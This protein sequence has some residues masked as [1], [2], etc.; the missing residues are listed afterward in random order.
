MEAI[1][2]LAG[3][4]ADFNNLLAAIMGFTELAL[5]DLPGGARA[6]SP[7]TSSGPHR[8]AP[9][10]SSSSGSPPSAARHRA[11]RRVDD[12]H[13]RRGGARACSARRSPPP[14][15]SRVSVEKDCVVRGNRVPAQQV[16]LNLGANAEHAM[17]RRRRAR[18]RVARDTLDETTIKSFPASRRA[19]W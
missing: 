10:A 11:P 15:T 3:G 17:P 5:L 16:L 12:R 6:L 7:P 9:V 8:R 4:I 1:G 14:S 19:P 13:H 18:V 2:T